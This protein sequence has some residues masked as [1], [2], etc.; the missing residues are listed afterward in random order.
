[1][2]RQLTR[3]IVLGVD[4]EKQKSQMI[5]NFENSAQSPFVQRKKILAQ[6]M[7]KVKKLKKFQAFSRTTKNSKKILLNFVEVV[8]WDWSFRLNGWKKNLILKN[9]VAS[10][11]E[12]EISAN[13]KKALSFAEESE[14]QK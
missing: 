10:L 6:K 9:G 12:V 8:F 1:M 7:K 3:K 11:T 13:E 5:G 4:Q 2:K 14:Y